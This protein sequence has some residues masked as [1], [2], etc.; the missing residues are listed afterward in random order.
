[1]VASIIIEAMLGREFTS[2]IACFVCAVCLCSFITVRQQWNSAGEL[3]CGRGLLTCV[4]VAPSAC[5]V[6]VVVVQVIYALSL[7]SG[8]RSH[9]PNQARRRI[10]RPAEA[11]LCTCLRL[12]RKEMRP[13]QATLVLQACVYQRLVRHP[14]L[15]NNACSP[16]A[17]SP[18][19]CHD[20]SIQAIPSE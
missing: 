12:Q 11:K 6:F 13:P 8:T 2:Q 15:N 14:T 18:T 3:I 5:H 7:F 4:R 9:P 20:M 1:M 10:R 17:L 16:P 19:S